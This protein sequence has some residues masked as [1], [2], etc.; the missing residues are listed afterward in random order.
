LAKSCAF[1]R[2]HDIGDHV[3]ADDDAR[4]CARTTFEGSLTTALLAPGVLMEP[5]VILL[6]AGL[7]NG[8][9]IGQVVGR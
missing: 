7:C 8:V 1:Q 2:L 5:L 6:A 3:V 4:L 9:I